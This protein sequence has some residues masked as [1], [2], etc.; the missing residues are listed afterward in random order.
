MKKRI[1]QQ[2]KINKGALKYIYIRGGIRKEKV[3]METK[4]RIKRRNRE[5]KNVQR[6]IKKRRKNRPTNFYI[7]HLCH[8]FGGIANLYFLVPKIAQKA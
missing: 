4:K 8:S 3:Y 7:N 5:E 6:Q 2:N 1:K